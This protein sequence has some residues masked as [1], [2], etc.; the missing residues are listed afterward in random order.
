MP[1]RPERN[2]YFDYRIDPY[3]MLNWCV[4]AEPA[5]PG[6]LIVGLNRKLDGP[7]GVLRCS[8]NPDGGGVNFGVP[9]NFT[10][11]INNETVCDLLADPTAGLF[12][13]LIEADGDAWDPDSSTPPC[14]LPTND[15]PRISLAT[16][17][18]PRA[19]T[20]NIKF[21][22]AMFDPVYPTS[23]VIDS[24]AEAPITH[25]SSTKRTVSYTGTYHL[26][27]FSPKG[28]TVGPAFKMPVK[29]V[30]EAH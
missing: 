3:P 29:M 20:T 4:G 12:L 13:S 11:R 6:N 23:F 8:D 18:K 21:Q 1:R 9:R 16:L 22:T 26:A 7:A 25:V 30:F 10:L 14:V 15:N 5:S 17:Y 27:R 2:A 19:K 28:K 24:D